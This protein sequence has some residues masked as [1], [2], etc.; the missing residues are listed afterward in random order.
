MRLEIYF[1]HVSITIP[2]IQTVQTKKTTIKIKCHF[3]TLG[4]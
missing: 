2:K 3:T 4:W 1:R